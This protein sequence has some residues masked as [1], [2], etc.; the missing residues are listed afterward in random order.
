MLISAI[1]IMIAVIKPIPEFMKKL[2]V[3]R[4]KK[5]AANIKELARR[6]YPTGI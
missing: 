5:P 4:T 6:A 2:D 1:V 3:A